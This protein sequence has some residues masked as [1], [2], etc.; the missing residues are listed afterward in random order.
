MSI[1]NT[2]KDHK[3][4]SHDGVWAGC[5]EGDVHNY[6]TPDGA[7]VIGWNKNYKDKIEF[8][9][10]A[11]ICEDDEF[12]LQYADANGNPQTIGVS[13]KTWAEAILHMLE[14]IKAKALKHKEMADK[15]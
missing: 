15:I 1:K 7:V 2:F 10:L 5:H 9:D 14:G 11:L 13:E 12:R 3:P 4:K 6:V 8:S